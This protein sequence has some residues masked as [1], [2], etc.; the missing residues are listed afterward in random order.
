MAI[1]RNHQ[2]TVW[3]V[4]AAGSTLLI[5]RRINASRL[6]PPAGGDRLWSN[7]HGFGDWVFRRGT[8]MAATPPL[9]L[10]FGAGVAG[11]QISF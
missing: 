11:K 3:Q 6:I 7:Q 1:K 4:S 2:I 8:A 5:R 10:N 9:A